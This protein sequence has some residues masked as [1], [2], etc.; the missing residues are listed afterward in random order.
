MLQGM[1]A[2]SLPPGGLNS[3]EGDL[4]TKMDGFFPSLKLS[5]Q[6]WPSWESLAIALHHG[7]ALLWLMCLGKPLTGGFGRGFEVRKRWGVAVS[8]DGV[9]S[10]C[11]SSSLKLFNLSE[12]RHDISKLHPKVGCSCGSQRGSGQGC[13]WDQPPAASCL[14]EEQPPFPSHPAGG[15][16]EEGKHRDFPMNLWGLSL[17]AFLFPLSPAQIC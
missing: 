7:K 8:E 3:G 11:L 9:S 6:F 14:G 15:G 16:A 17:T 4:C 12:R 2:A 13:L 5:S 10:L 1:G